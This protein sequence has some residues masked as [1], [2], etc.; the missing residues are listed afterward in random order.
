[1]W[2]TVPKPTTPTWT[3]TNPQGKEQY[4]QPSIAYD[5]VNVFYDGINQSQWTDVAKPTYT[6]GP[7]LVLNGGFLLNADNWTLGDGWVWSAGKVSQ[8]TG[9]NSAYL[10]QTISIIPSVAY[11]VQFDSVITAVGVECV[12]GIGDAGGANYLNV[13][14]TRHVSQILFAGPDDADISFISI[15]GFLGSVT[16]VSVKR[17]LNYWTK[18]PKPI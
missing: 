3:N 13:Y 14:Q 11:L 15:P 16:N 5:D 2:T 6:Y 4:D 12:L 8:T 18:V 17:I 7:E 9:A 1:M 10:S